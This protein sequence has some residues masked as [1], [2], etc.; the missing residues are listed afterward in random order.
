[1]SAPEQFHV[2][3]KHYLSLAQSDGR[4][5]GEELF[6]S[7]SQGDCGGGTDQPVRTL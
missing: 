7:Q 4:S 1:M 3:A 6:G 2:E 5:V